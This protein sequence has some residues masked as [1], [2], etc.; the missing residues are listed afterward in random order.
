MW[1][2]DIHGYTLYCHVRRGTRIPTCLVGRVTRT[3]HDINARHTWGTSSH[4]LGR[5]GVTYMAGSPKIACVLVTPLRY[6]NNIKTLAGIVS[7]SGTLNL[8]CVLPQGH[9]RHKAERQAHRHPSH[10]PQLRSIRSSLDRS[11]DERRYSWRP[12]LPGMHSV[13]II[14]NVPTRWID[15]GQAIPTR[16]IASRNRGFPHPCPGP[17]S[18]LCHQYTN[19]R[20]Y[21]IRGV[22]GQRLHQMYAVYCTL[23]PAREVTSYPTRLA[24]LQD[25]GR[26]RNSVWY[27]GSRGDGWRS[28]WGRTVFH[29]SSPLADPSSPN[30]VN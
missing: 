15:R 11:T 19:S 2:S 27:E 13:R 16:K 18:G 29:V 14:P 5:E 4:L 9:L 30:L 28:S 7:P 1:R 6:T 25:E 12:W 10:K 24:G 3:H 20:L 21:P 17:V 23:Q 8:F 26:R 22:D